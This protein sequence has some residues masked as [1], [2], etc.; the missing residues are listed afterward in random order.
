MHLSVIY[1]R[2]CMLCYFSGQ[3]DLANISVTNVQ[4]LSSIQELRRVSYFSTINTSLQDDRLPLN[5]P[6]K[7][8][9]FVQ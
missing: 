7:A 9:L 8:R 4:I 6:F 2:Y 3:I 5:S 1:L